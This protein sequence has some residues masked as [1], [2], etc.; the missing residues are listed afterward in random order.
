MIKCQLGLRLAAQE[1]I[2]IS[3]ANVSCGD[4]LVQIIV[5]LTH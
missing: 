5:F 3:S 1:D 2:S 4:V